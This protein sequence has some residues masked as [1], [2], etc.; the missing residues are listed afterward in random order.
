[1]HVDKN[2]TPGFPTPRGNGWWASSLRR[3][4][5]NGFFS[6][7]SPSERQPMEGPFTAP[8]EVK[9][10]RQERLT[11]HSESFLRRAK[12]PC[13]PVQN[14]TVFPWVCGRTR[15]SA[16]TTDDG[17]HG[18]PDAG[19]RGALDSSSAFRRPTRKD[20]IRM[21]TGRAGKPA[22]PGPMNSMIPH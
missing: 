1:M 14:G 13:P 22:N 8:N 19:G 10:W 18:R 16:P 4:G 21:T 3:A 5:R 15:G 17:I 12:N 7:F 6:R 2:F 20:D 11:C 9:P